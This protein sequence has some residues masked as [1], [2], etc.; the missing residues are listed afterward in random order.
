MPNIQTTINEF[1]AGIDSDFD[2]HRIARNKYRQIKNGRVVDVDGKIGTIKPILST[3]LKSVLT[4][5]FEPLAYKTYKGISYIL[6][7]NKIT[8][9]SEIG[10]YPAPNSILTL[11]PAAVGFSQ[12]YAPLWNFTGA[13]NDQYEPNPTRE[14]FRTGLFKLDIDRTVTIVCR[15]DYDKTINIYFCDGVE[16]DKIINSGFNSD[17]GVQVQERMYGNNSF[18][19]FVEIMNESPFHPI[20]SNIELISGGEIPNGGMKA[21]FRYT[22]EDY[23]PTSFLAET[24]FIMVSDINDDDELSVSGGRTGTKSSKACKITLTALDPAYKYIEVGYIVYFGDIFEPRIIN[25][26]YLIDRGTLTASFTI[27]GSEDFSVVDISQLITKKPKEKIASAIADVDKRLFRADVK[28]KYGHSIELAEFAKRLEPYHDVS[29]E[30]NAN[31]FTSGGINVATDGQY[32]SWSNTYNYTGYF[33]GEPYPFAVVYVFDD[34]TESEAY[35]TKGFDD[36]EMTRSASNENGIFRFPNVLLRDTHHPGSPGSNGTGTGELYAGRKVSVMGVI[37][38]Q[39]AANTYYTS[40]PASNILR[41]NVIGFYYVRGERK[42]NLIYQGISLFTYKFGDKDNPNW[43]DFIAKLGGPYTGVGGITF[44]ASD[45]SFYSSNNFAPFLIKNHTAGAENAPEIL[46]YSTKDSQVAWGILSA[47]SSK[48][49]DALD[50]ALNGSDN[51]MENVENRKGFFSLDHFF[52]KSMPKND[53][54][55]FRIYTNAEFNLFT[56]VNNPAHYENQLSLF[57]VGDDYYTPGPYSNLLFRFAKARNILAWQKIPY[58]SFVSYFDEGNPQNINSLF[59]FA[60][61]NSAILDS[62][63]QSAN[64]G[65]LELGINSYIGLV[66]P[67]GIGDNYGNGL[68]NLYYQSPLDIDITDIV[69]VKTTNY[70]KISDLQPISELDDASQI[71]YNGDCF[72][73]RAAIRVMSNPGKYPTAKVNDEYSG[74][75]LGSIGLTVS[76]LNTITFGTILEYVAE[77]EINVAYRMED[78]NKSYYPAGG[79]ENYTEAAT[80]NV[81]QE[82]DLINMGYSKTTSP[83]TYRG[84]NDDLPIYSKEFP[85]RIMGSNNHILNGFKDGYRNF[86]LATYKDYEFG[87]G[88]IVSIESLYGNLICIMENFIGNVP[89]NERV[90]M[91]TSSGELAIGFGDLLP[92]KLQTSSQIIGCQ[93]KRSIVNTGVFIYGIDVRKRTIWSMA[94]GD[95]VNPISERLS[96]STEINKIIDN[97]SNESDQTVSI[98][99]TPINGEGISSGY[100]FKHKG[101]YWTFFKENTGLQT[102]CFN[103]KANFFELETDYNS[104]FYFTINDDFYSVNPFEVTDKSFKNQGLWQHDAGPSVLEFYDTLYPM[105]VKFVVNERADFNKIFNNLILIT[106]GEPFQLLEYETQGQSSNQNPFIP[107]GPLDVWRKP[108]FKEEKWIFPI[109][110]ALVSKAVANNNFG[111]K[112][113]MQGNW[114]EILL[115]YNQNKPTFIKSILTDYTI[116]NI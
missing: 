82:S 87:Y 13:N 28:Q 4:F 88:R 90:T 61:A 51:M 50:I 106:S 80:Q 77:H 22:S 70:F 25:K 27:L 102:I 48:V 98:K 79:T 10:C 67:V 52:K 110:R 100:D 72:L 17:T 93:N 29:R 64:A 43:S 33:S 47:A 81:L 83:L 114:I 24:N 45:Y 86:G 2:N 5:G 101:V 58:D 9:E 20:I 7:H 92:E 107:V 89:V 44:G 8:G 19:H 74:G 113:H 41:K 91:G 69:D 59:S 95:G 96:Y 32:K 39:T 68:T 104:P 75:I 15:E 111:V 42:K 105:D 60:Q 54:V 16:P 97:Y 112:S 1:T 94:P 66:L 40:L 84:F 3:V 6:S 71:F 63:V 30:L 76:K 26:K 116:T 56:S 12:S 14:F 65:S 78:G 49:Y 85:T 57:Y 115:R 11:N 109:N 108:R 34:G 103:Q 62:K 36:F 31:E 37:F 73:Q 99:D 38:D 35:P 18:P 55:A 46:Y 23:N 53:V 21:F